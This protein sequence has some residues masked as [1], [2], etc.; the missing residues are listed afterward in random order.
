MWP[1]KKKKS[2][3]PNIHLTVEIT[4]HISDDELL[5]R[6]L[7]KQAT[8]MHDA[9]RFDKAVD[10]L[11]QVAETRKNNCHGIATLLRLPLYLQKAGRIDEAMIEFNRLY[12]GSYERIKHCQPHLDEA[13][14]IN[15]AAHD[16]RIIKQKIALAKKREARRVG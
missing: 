1:F 14:V 8:K 5:A 10:L 12:D 16:R 4:S 6:E 11:Y 3:K 7:S 15:Y 2:L 9:K 13:K